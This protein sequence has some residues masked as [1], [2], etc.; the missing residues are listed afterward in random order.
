MRRKRRRG[1]SCIATTEGNKVMKRIGA[2]DAL[3]AKSGNAGEENN[4]L[5]MEKEQQCFRKR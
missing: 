1:K 4:A 2:T 5:S 3:I